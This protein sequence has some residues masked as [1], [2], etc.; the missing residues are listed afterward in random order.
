MTVVSALVMLPAGVLFPALLRAANTPP[1]SQTLDRVVRKETPE[2]PNHDLHDQ[3]FR[4]Q[5][6]RDADFQSALRDGERGPCVRVWE[7]RV[8]LLT[9]R[10]MLSSGIRTAN[11]FAGYLLDRGVRRKHRDKKNPLRRDR[12]YCVNTDWP[13]HAFFCMKCNSPRSC[14]ERRAS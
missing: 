10:Y 5:V 12:C 3:L 14:R 1:A 7:I 13:Y 9:W 2:G 6:E 11:R 4:E 8:F